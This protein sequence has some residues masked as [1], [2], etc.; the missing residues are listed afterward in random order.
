MQLIRSS[1][2]LASSSPPPSSSPSA[3]SSRRSVPG[4]ESVRAELVRPYIRA[5]PNRTACDC[6]FDLNCVRKSSSGRFVS[7]APLPSDPMSP[8]RSDCK[9]SG[10]KSS[11]FRKG[12]DVTVSAPSSSSQYRHS[13]SYHH[14]NNR[15]MSS[16]R[17]SGSL[18]RQ[19]RSDLCRN[20]DPPPPYSER[21][22]S[23]IPSFLSPAAFNSQSRDRGKGDS[24]DATASH[25][26]SHTQSSS[27]RRKQ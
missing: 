10:Q 13:G 16:S 11:L 12:G 5:P 25:H 19:M 27:Q 21:R 1:L 20:D 26:P 8:L 9:S 18:S 15:S 4:M 14:N 2:S 6:C 3:P 24:S 23:A 7:P 17:S 22:S